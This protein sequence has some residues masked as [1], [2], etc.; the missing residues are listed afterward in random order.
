MDGDFFKN[1]YDGMAVESRTSK[2]ESERIARQT[3]VRVTLVESPME[4]IM[5]FTIRAS[6]FLAEPGCRYHDEFDANDFASSHLLVWVG[7]E[8][9]GTLRLRWFNGFARFERMAI[10]PEYRSLKVFL[11]LVRFAMRLCAAKGYP[12]VV[13][14]SREAGVGFWKRFG[15]SVVG[16]PIS[17]HGEQLYPLRYRLPAGTHRLIARGTADAGT[18]HFEEALSYPEQRLVEC[19]A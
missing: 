18:S 14:L 10:R 8:P 13:G 5:A 17:Y 12:E 4:Q 16:T 19:A 6:V 7:D 3:D 9:V 11:R 15:A 2:I 1:T